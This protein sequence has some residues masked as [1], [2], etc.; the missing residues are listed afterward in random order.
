MTKINY[1]LSLALVFSVGLSAQSDKFWAT[2]N[3]KG[4]I[5]AINTTRAG[6]PTTYQLFELNAANLKSVLQTA[7]QRDLTKRQTGVIISIPNAA[8]TIEHFEMFEASNF[9]PGLQARYPNIRAYVG[10]GV[11][12]KGSILRISSGVKGVQGMI[13]RDGASS[14]FIEKYAADQQVYAVYE[15][16]RT[17]GSL[18][19]TCSTEDQALAN[20]VA[21]QAMARQQMSNAGELR[22]LRLAQSVN[23][24]YTTYFGGTVPDALEGIN[25]TLTRVNGVDERDLAVHL[26]LIENTDDVIYTNATTDPYSTPDNWNAEVQATLTAV[27]GN[28]NYDIGHLFAVLPVP[29]GG[30]GN[31]GCVGCV[32]VN[33][34]KGSGYTSPSDAIP[35][36]DNFDIDYVVHEMGHQ[37]GGSH[38]FS[39]ANEG[40]GTN[41]EP[42][43]GSTIMGYAGIVPGLNVQTHSDDYF[44]YANVIQIQQNLATKTCPVVTPI[45]D[46]APTV[47]AGPD[48]IM[49]YSTP[50]ILTASGAD[51]DGDALLYCWE[52]SDNVT[53]TSTDDNSECSTTKASGPN[54]RTYDPTS[55]PSRFMPRIQSVVANNL[56]TTFG[57]F[58]S[59]AVSSVARDLNFAVTVRDIS[60]G[61][62]QTATDYMKV[63]VT[64][65]AGPFLVT[66][67][68]TVVSYVAG[69]N[70]T[71][72][73]DVAGT[74]GNGV[75]TPTVDI[76]YSPTSAFNNLTLLASDVPNDG[77][78]VVT[79]PTTTGSTNRIMVRGHNHIFYDIS[80]A[81]FTITAATSSFSV[82]FSGVAGEQHKNV[83]QGSTVTYTIPYNPLAGFTGT[84]TF[85]LAGQPAGS[86]VTFSP[87]NVTAS[88]NVILSVTP[89]AGATVQLYSLVVTATSGS[90]VKT[91]PFYLDVKDGNFTGTTLIS[92]ANNAT[93]QSVSPALTYTADAAATSYDVQIA[94]DSA[95]TNIVA[96]GT[97]LTTTF[98]AGGLAEG[99]TYY[100]RV[101]PKNE[102]CQGTLSAVYSFQT[103]QTVC[104]ATA[105]TSPNVPKAISA[106]GTPTVTSTITVGAG[107]PISRMTVTA[108]ITHSWVSD[109][110]VKLTSPSGTQI[111][112]IQNPC[113]DQ[114]NINNVT[115]DDLGGVPLCATNP[116]VTGLI[117]PTQLL[118]TFNGENPAG[119]WTL[120]VSDNTAGDGGSLTAW[121]LNICNEQPL[122]TAEQHLNDLAI[123]PNPNN[124]TFNVSF[125]PN[126]NEDVKI[127][128][129]DIRGRQIFNKGYVANGLFQQILDLGHPSSG[130]Y[131]IQIENG[132]TRETRKIV[133]E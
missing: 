38:S 23:A 116:A 130:V 74:T 52:G 10:K 90:V 97:S 72:T 1:F 93:G 59:E 20:D 48:Y 55:S 57:G 18:P 98:V 94:S 101:Q 39:Y 43:S 51:E 47:N 5:P 91:V 96:S 87:D 24:Q 81:N 12:N 27:I 25:N 11:E 9:A 19:W 26:E 40:S 33:N 129:F 6:F 121:S 84:T 115:F 85:S 62:G 119:V 123:Y 77:S 104:G 56:T 117:R 70:Q 112:L 44:V 36:G 8:G 46:S 103:G 88:G 114:N 108:N 79:I 4:L 127:G 17:K 49:P 76:Y 29:Q 13:L 92:P 63:S 31:A 82:A 133:V 69:S 110:T 99:T 58:T 126:Q 107:T 54:W 60:T 86:V 105:A 120:T 67:P 128:V 95:F 65:A 28:A 22:T 109:L 111:T 68:N 106:S 80:N 30:G 15:S 118:S 35:M 66:S 14:E 3:A 2:T 42:G 113:D 34:Q 32:C 89:P 73:W 37:L 102:A 78:E 16:Q 41:V 50:F 132:G 71:V 75:N 7:P 100:W 83:C 125:T 61:V 64:T 131:L 124:G 53:A 122:G 45:L 21:P